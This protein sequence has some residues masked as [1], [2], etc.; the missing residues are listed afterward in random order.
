MYSKSTTY[1]IYK[2]FN[3][4]F[5]F[6]KH[7]APSCAMSLNGNCIHVSVPR[8]SEK[9]F[10]NPPPLLSTPLP[11]TPLCSPSPAPLDNKDYKINK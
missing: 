8:A 7:L 9:Y 2:Y 5:L 11:P 4:H 3:C 6:F 1:S 10:S